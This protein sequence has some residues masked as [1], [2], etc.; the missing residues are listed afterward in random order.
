[1]NQKFKYDRGNCEHNEMKYEGKIEWARQRAK[2]F[3]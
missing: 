1:V 3:G 2:I